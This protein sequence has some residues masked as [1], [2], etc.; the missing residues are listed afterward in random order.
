MWL[1]DTTSPSTS[2]SVTT[3]V[4]NRPSPPSSAGSPPAPI[5]ETK[6]LADRH[7]GR[8]QPADQHLVDELLRALSGELVVERDHDQLANAERGDQLDLGVEAHQQLRRRLG[9]DHG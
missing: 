4:S 6:V 8:L 9:A 3:R 2:T 5:A 7:V 1:E